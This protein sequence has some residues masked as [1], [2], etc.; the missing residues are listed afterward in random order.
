M[1]KVYS[2]RTLVPIKLHGVTFQ[3]PKI[4]YS[5]R[6]CSVRISAG[7]LPILTDVFFRFPSVPPE[8]CWNSALIT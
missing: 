4:L 2:Y 5:F 8:K 6:K 3:E 1:Y 7:K